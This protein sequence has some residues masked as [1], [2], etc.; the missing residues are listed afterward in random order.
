MVIK[1][2]RF[3]YKKTP[4]SSSMDDDDDDDHWSYNWILKKNVDYNT[5]D[6]LNTVTLFNIDLNFACQYSCRVITEYN[7][8]E[9][10]AQMIIIVG[11]YNVRKNNRKNP[12]FFSEKFIFLKK[13]QKI[14]KNFSIEINE[15]FDSTMKIIKKFCFFFSVT[16]SSVRLGCWL[17][18]CL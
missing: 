16:Y 3:I 6:L 11:N 2:T 15:N 1:D 7:E 14:D 17:W 12:W 4:L 13:N 5:K 8:S 9:N 18:L 10:S